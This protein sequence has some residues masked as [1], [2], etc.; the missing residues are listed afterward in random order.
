MLAGI[1]RAPNIL[2]PN[3]AGAIVR[4][5][6]VIGIGKSGSWPKEK[7]IEQSCEHTKMHLLN[8]PILGFTLLPQK[9]ECWYSRKF[10]KRSFFF[11]QYLLTPA[12]VTGVHI[13]YLLA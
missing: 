11:C 2:A 7:H 5:A 9:E 3:R 6:G 13:F 12:T 8:S 10:Q 1:Y 4:G